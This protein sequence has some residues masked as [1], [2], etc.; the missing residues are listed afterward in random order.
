MAS[1]PSGPSAPSYDITISY[2]TQYGTVPDNY[3]ASAGT[4][5]YTDEM[6][7]T[8]TTDGLVHVGWYETSTFDEDSKAVSG[9]TLPVE[10]GSFTL[11]AKWEPIVPVLVY[12]HNLK[13]IADA[14]RSANGTIATYKPSEMA[15]A[16]AAS[17]PSTCTGFLSYNSDA[18]FYY[19]DGSG[20]SASTSSRGTFTVA[21]RS[22]VVAYKSSTITRVT[23]SG[24]ATKLLQSGGVAVIFATGD[25]NF[26]V[27]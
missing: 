6:L 14:I 23:V 15:G 7:P 13:A 25:F 20:N 5:T 22:I 3:T 16:I 17:G 26:T 21:K 2:M 18:T 1:I 11:Y 12:E 24:S 9:S 27:N 8:L 4:L 19:V 10:Y